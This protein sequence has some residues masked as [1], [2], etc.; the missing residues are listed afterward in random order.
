MSLI[1][2]Q[3]IKEDEKLYLEFKS[4]WYWENTLKP[5]QN[6]WGEFLKDFVGLINGSPEYVNENKYLIIG[7]D[8]KEQEFNKRIKKIELSTKYQIIDSL[9][10]E[11]LDKLNQ[12]F[13][14]EEDSTYLYNNFTL[15][16][17][18]IDNKP[19]IVFEIKPAKYVLVLRKDL[20]DRKRT[21]K[22]NNV[23]IRA[24]KE[25]GEPEVLNASPVMIERLKNEIRN[26]QLKLD[27]EEK[28]DKS[29]EKTINLYVQN[30]SIF[31]LSTPVKD[32]IW[33]ENGKH[34]NILYELYPV[35][36]N[37][38]NIDFIYIHDKTNQVKTYEYLQKNKI[39]SQDA[40]RWILIDDGLKKDR[41]GI[42]KKFDA[43][44]V[45][46][47]DEFA[48]EYLYKEY[49]EQDIYYQGNFKNQKQIKNFIEPYTVQ[50]NEKNALTILTEWYSTLSKPLMLVKGFG[51]VGKTTLVQ[52]F[53]NELY[54]DNLAK[55]TNLKILF[56]DSKD[57]LSEI[58]KQGKIDNIY[59]FYNALANKKELTKRFN[60]ELLE[61]SVDNGNLLIVLDGIDEVITKLANKFDINC[62]IS[63][64][65]DNYSLG[66]EKTKII[67]TCRDSFWNQ[68]NFNAFQIN[69]IEIMPF[70][71]E[72]VEKFFSNYF[73]RSSKEFEKSISLAREFPL[74]KNNDEIY[75]PYIL[76]IIA[77]MLKQ[78]KE[79]GNINRNDIDS[80]ILHTDLT[81]DYF[82]GRLC[83]REIEKIKSIDIDL[84][85]EFFM[86]MAVE[87]DG[88]VTKSSY[89]KLLRKLPY[90]S[91]E[92]LEKLKG[93]PLI[94][95]NR[96]ILIF[97]YD[98][99]KEYFIN[100]YL[101]QFFIQKNISDFD[102]NIQELLLEYIKY[103][104]TFTKNICQR[105]GF[106]E[107]LQLFI[108]E[109][110]EQVISKLIEKENYND[111]RLISSL[112]SILL[113][114]LNLSS[115]KNDIENRTK[116]ILD[117]FGKNL[118]YLSI[119]NIFGEDIK[120]NY[121]TFDFTNTYIN[122]AWF[123]NYQYFWECKLDTS[124]SF[125]KCTFKD[126]KPRDRVKLPNIHDKLF[127]ECDSLGIDDLLQIENESKIAKNESLVRKIKKIFRHF[128]DGG[129]FKEKKID[130]TRKKCDTIMLD[131]LIK[132]KIISQYRNP[133]RPTLKQYKVS[134][135]Y[136][137][138]IS[139]LN[140][141]G[142]NY[143][144]QKILKLMY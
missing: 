129:A 136:D 22:K 53:L 38:V 49:F 76:D 27:K 104:N 122:N 137:N 57:I 42:K 124:S 72:L 73:D 110:I 43:N 126:L 68:N 64:I 125:Y 91:N 28:L 44:Y 98:F 36:S 59:D 116:L 87:F 18:Y 5:T 120:G 141:G 60:K 121:P 62:F 111:R 20:C 71:I 31:S 41:E 117:I 102:E 15:K 29:K 118:N 79:L 45:F 113:L 32:K 75:L 96:D 52:Y 70:T 63:T 2:R 94:D 1:Y 82:V 21:E 4:E 78:Q 80:K 16:Y 139:I 140:Q 51:G 123:E 106:D 105:I 26:Y 138:I 35:K 65:Y 55:E 47:L 25:N 132:N 69:T 46:S 88:E 77:D 3:L 6:D 107:E 37:F 100:L 85:L 144:F 86:K 127:I 83:N 61:L 13:F 50:T 109:L 108:I 112:L 40:Q 134:E 19:I 74:K 101:S 93:H 39:I 131:L 89:P 14:A 119:I 130:D 142:S 10:E 115:N 103:D 9:K 48:L 143:E 11:I 33:K 97:R 90:Q 67:I 17:E 34:V 133:D 7:I 30:N 128:E 24:L 12:F 66:N 114:S 99:F 92:I 54:K 81:N 56:I 84:Q 58:Y 135:E 8:E 95:Y 23:F